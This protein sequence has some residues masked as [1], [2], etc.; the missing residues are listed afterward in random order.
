MNSY[1]C[2]PIQKLELNDYSIIPIRYMDI[3]KIRK[4]RNEQINVL[5]QEKI[6]SENQQTAYYESM[7]KESFS[8]NQ[9]TII[10][11]S[12]LHGKICCNFT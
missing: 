5:R 11:F 4:W 7:I 6:L 8:E 3:Q 12:F 2:L 10:L 9:P 1:K